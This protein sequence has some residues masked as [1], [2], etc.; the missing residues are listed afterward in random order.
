MSIK[1]K[2]VLFVFREERITPILLIILW[3]KILCV[4]EDLVVS[5][6]NFVYLAK[7]GHPS[8]PWSRMVVHGSDL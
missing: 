2:Q 1:S 8:E 3:N 7:L 4:V 5:G 6:K